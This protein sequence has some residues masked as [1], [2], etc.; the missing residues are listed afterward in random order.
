[1]AQYLESALLFKVDVV[2]LLSQN[3][4]AGIITL[5]LRRPESDTVQGVCARVVRDLQGVADNGGSELTALPGCESRADC[6]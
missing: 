6:G 5:S 4:V 2:R 1:M 3:N